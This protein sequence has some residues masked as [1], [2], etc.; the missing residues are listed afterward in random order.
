MRSEP[1]EQL[2]R[3]LLSDVAQTIGPECREEIGQFARSE[4]ALNPHRTHDARELVD[5]VQQYIHDCFIDT[6]WPACP[7]HPNHPLAF[8]GREWCCPAD[9]VPAAALGQLAGRRP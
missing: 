5:A 9:G 3:L 7:R 6:T 1:F 4:V 8:N 2:F